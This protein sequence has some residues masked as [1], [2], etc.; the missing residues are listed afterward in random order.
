MVASFRPDGARAR[1]ALL[2]GA[3]AC[4]AALGAAA[5]FG[6][7]IGLI[8]LAGLGVLTAAFVSPRVGIA[9]LLITAGIDGF[10]KHAAATP[11]AYLLKDAL[12]AALVAGVIVR[13]GVRPLDRPRLRAG[14]L[15]VWLLY[16]AYLGTQLLHPSASFSGALAALR[17][18]ALFALLVPVG[19]YVLTTPRRIA[20]VGAL[21]AAVVAVC[22]ISALVQHL[23]GP[24]WVALG[25]GFAKASLHYST[26]TT[27]RDQLVPGTVASSYRAYGTLVDPAAMGL[28]CAYGALAAIAGLGRART[29]RARFGFAAAT[30]AAS[31]GLFLSQTRSAAVA[32]AAGLVVLGLLSAGDRRTRPVVFAGLLLVGLALPAGIALTHGTLIERFTGAGS[33]AYAA[34]TRDRSRTIVMDELP[35]YP[36][37][38]GLGSTGAGGMLRDDS[39]LS[40]DNVYVATLYETGIP[41][42]LAFAALQLALLV[43]TIRSALGARDIRARTV[44]AGAAAGQVGLLAAA[45]LTQGAFDYAP[46]AQAFWLLGGAALNRAVTEEDV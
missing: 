21:V 8:A 16:V 17:A 28:T 6:T 41:G 29:W 24:A 5:G 38:H 32:L 2:G 25:P 15:F 42:L 19:A 44:F 40:I 35:S 10:V 43:A 18:H 12:L 39:G 36:L 1:L 33:V 3:L 20:A 11:L 26:F 14:T 4:A 23:M 45:S 7:P 30:G 31:L 22:G 9:A 27:A 13:A 46:I 34:Q 37:G